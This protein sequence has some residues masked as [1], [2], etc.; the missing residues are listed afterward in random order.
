[1]HTIN[2]L[3]LFETKNFCIAP[4]IHTNITN[5][6]R[7]LLCCN[8][9]SVIASLN[10]SS[11]NEV[12]TSEVYK[13]IRQDLVNDLPIQGC[14]GCYTTEKLGD[15][16]YR[17]IFN[18]RAKLDLKQKRIDLDF[19]SVDHGNKTKTPISYDIRA[20]NLCNLKCVMCGPSSSS[21]YA[22]EIDEN[23]KLYDYSESLLFPQKIMNMKTDWFDDLEKSI[24]ASNNPVVKLLGGEPTIIPQ[25]IDM[26][27]KLVLAKNT[28]GKLQITTNLTNLNKKIKNILPKFR[29][30]EVTCSVDGI[31]SVLEYIRYPIKYP[32]WQTNFESLLDLSN[33]TENIMININLVVQV[34]NL[35]QLPKFLK[36]IAEK[37]KDSKNFMGF[38]LLKL[39]TSVKNNPLRVHLIPYKDRLVI[40]DELN[41][42]SKSF[43]PD[44]IKRSELKYTINSILDTKEVDDSDKVSLA[45]FTLKRDISR[46]ISLKDYIPEVYKLI[47][48]EYETEKIKI[49]NY[50]ERH[51]EQTTI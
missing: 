2:L 22:K 31:D 12:W 24:L 11:F 28:G 7:C 35:Y 50:L 32:A 44:I 38:H 16:S 18:N 25:Y 51:N 41:E 34:Y 3:E 36:Y 47:E 48:N 27:E 26:L 39:L 23:K 20:S 13:N 33:N 1:M 21:E 40:A 10:E 45:I 29:R 14:E 43:D 4:F 8:N 17:Q 6:N 9:E 30:S 5:D 42:I 49:L 15:I 37:T 19:L 46:G